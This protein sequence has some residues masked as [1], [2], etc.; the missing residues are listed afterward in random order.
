[1]VDFH[2]LLNEF[3]HACRGGDYEVSEQL[4]EQIIKFV[5]KQA[6]HGNRVINFLIKELESSRSFWMRK[7]A[8]EKEK[9]ERYEKVLKT[10]AEHEY[11]GSIGATGYHAEFKSMAKNALEV[12]VQ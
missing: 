4:R 3:E 9:A 10:I 7:Y 8:D 11:C 6:E 1:M 12:N 2:N 5:E